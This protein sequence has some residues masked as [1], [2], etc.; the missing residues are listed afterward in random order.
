VEFLPG[1]FEALRWL[2]QSAHAVVLVTN[3]SAVGQGLLSLEE[4]VAI[5]RRVVAEIETHGGRVDAWY[6]CPHRPDHG[7]ECRKPAPGMLW[8][9]QKDLVLDLA[10]CYLVGDAVSD[11][12][13]ARAVGARGILVL[14]GRGR[15]QAALLGKNNVAS[16]PVAAD[17]AAALNCIA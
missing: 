8:R 11:I 13:A 5:N 15:D 1:A 17:L 3:Q 16:C 14:T 12:E 6:L 9:A 4:A 2:R 10:Q 7:C